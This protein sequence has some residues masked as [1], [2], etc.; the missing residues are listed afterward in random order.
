[1]PFRAIVEYENR[2]EY[3]IFRIV[4][5]F[6]GL[7]SQILALESIGNPSDG[8]GLGAQGMSPRSHSGRRIHLAKVCQLTNTSSRRSPSGA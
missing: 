7:S 5:A 6:C 8:T 2:L 4:R 1:M 3:P